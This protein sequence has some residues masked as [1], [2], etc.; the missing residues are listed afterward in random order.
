VIVSA[1]STVESQPS[2][3]V[4]PKVI[5]K[6]PEYQN[7]ADLMPPTYKEAVSVENRSENERY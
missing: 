5:E 2:Q 4:E 7:I 3:Q 6:P 1:L